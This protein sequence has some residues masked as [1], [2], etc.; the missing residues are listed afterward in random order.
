MEDLV[1]VVEDTQLE[2]SLYLRVIQ[3]HLQSE[4]AVRPELPQVVMEGPEVQL[5]S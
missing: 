3:Y 1:E 4:P 2:L 5:Q